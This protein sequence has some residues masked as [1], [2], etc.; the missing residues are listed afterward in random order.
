VSA[1]RARIRNFI[2]GQFVEPVSGKYL[3]NIEP[4]TGKPYSLVPDSDT[5]DVELAVAAAE[6]AFPAWSKTPAADRSRILLRLADL[7]ERDLEKLARA[8]SIDTGKPLSLARSLDIPRAASNFRFFATAILHTENEAHVTDGVAFNYTLRQPR[9]IAGLISPWNL[10][11]YLLSWKIAPA[12]AVG[13]TAIAK[14]SELTPM[15]A[16]QLC[17][18]CVE[19]G[20]PKGV[21]NVV[22]GTGPNVGAAIT[23]HPKIDTISFTGGTVTGRKVAEAAAP[24][25]KKVSLEL[26]GKNPNI[27]FADADLDA[28]IAGSVRSSFANQGQVCLC[29][30]RVFVER[31]VYKNFVDRFIEKA[32]ELKQ[33]D[34]LEEKTEQGAI[35]SK[36]QLD[37]VKFYVNLAQKE[38]GKIALGGKAPD[39]ISDRCRDGYFFPP[40]VLTDLPVSC[41]TNRE[42]IFG[43]V[44]TITPFDNEEE[45]I[46]YANDCDYGLASSIWTQNLSRAHRV[47]E[48]IHTGTVWINCW[49]V[50]D[51]RVPFGGMKQSGVGREGGEEALRFFTE[52]KNVC[53]AK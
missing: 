4:A 1:E 38:G 6:K 18:L 33:G 31:S 26:G 15:T 37:K 46:G 24:L 21:L 9:G 45:V 7:I 8:E 41:R 13:N 17:E 28:A 5:R 27:V 2:G 39:S 34:P 49:L 20:M 52:P 10:P 22:H 47:A 11:L 19:A 35:V 12:I 25:F 23:A 51:L 42:E 32:A 50:R 3:D 48:K 36:T 16:F 53:I 14:P 43:P 29:G 30:S 44:V 40:T